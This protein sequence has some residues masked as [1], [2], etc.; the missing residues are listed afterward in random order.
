MSEPL[1]KQLSPDDVINEFY[2]NNLRD[3]IIAR[4]DILIF[5]QYNPDE[6]V[7]LRQGPSIGNNQVPTTIDVKAK[8]AIKQSEDQVAKKLR[9]MQCLS[10]LRKELKDFRV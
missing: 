7:G 10:K 1:I 6:R 5:S 3:Y 8:E 2:N 9:V 4:N